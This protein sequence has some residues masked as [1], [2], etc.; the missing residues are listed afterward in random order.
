MHP[1][2]EYKLR[3]VSNARNAVFVNLARNRPLGKDYEQVGLVGEW[4]FGRFCGQMPRTRPGGDGGVDFRIPCTFTV[5]VKT[6]RKGYY[7]LVEEGKV[8]ADI[9]VLAHYKATEDVDVENRTIWESG[10]AELVGWC[11]GHELA[12]VPPKDTGMGVVNHALTK[13]QLRPMDELKAMMNVG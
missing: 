11:W 13:K 5:D 3:E 1:F 4:E 12:A 9:Y 6:S 7:L 2:L 10:G 8:K